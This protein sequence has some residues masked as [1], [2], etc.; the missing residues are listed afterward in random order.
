MI[1]LTFLFN[2][3]SLKNKGGRLWTKT[4]MG[5]SSMSTRSSKS[6]IVFAYLTTASTRSLYLLL[7]LGCFLTT[8]NEQ[9]S[10]WRSKR[11]KNTK[12]GV[13]KGQRRDLL[14]NDAPRLG[15]LHRRSNLGTSP[16]TSSR[17]VSQSSLDTKKNWD[18]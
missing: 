12:V 4:V 13:Y 16:Q 1:T 10:Q 15:A 9:E 3:Y 11:K 8:H 14:R 2:C 7:S 5:Q 17:R 18:F 6:S